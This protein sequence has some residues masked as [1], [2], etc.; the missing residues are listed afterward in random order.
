MKVVKN[1]LFDYGLSIYQDQDGFKF[2]LDSI[3]LSEFVELNKVVNTIVDFCSGNGAVPLI[4][5]TKTSA[6]IIGFEVQERPYELAFNSIKL[7][8]LSRQI[9]MV[10]ANLNEVLEY[11]LPESVD[12]VTCNPPY[13]KVNPESNINETMEKAIARH[14]LETN[15]EEI[16][17]SS[18]YILK[19]KGALYMVHRPE[20][21]VEILDLLKT[22]KFAVKK[23][24]FIYSNYKKPALMVLI[25]A[26]KNGLDGLKVNPPIN[27]LDYKTYKNIFD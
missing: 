19:N 20:R 1:D 18:R 24:Q 22:Y 8:K 25:K 11:V 4:L 6:K 13:F 27:V 7:N 16:I 21:L 26:T 2:S 5:S 10:N 14:E 23:L 3:L 15:L 17:M 9:K 12:I